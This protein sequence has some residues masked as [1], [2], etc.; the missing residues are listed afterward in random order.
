MRRSI[1]T[2]SL[3][4]T[5]EEKL[6]AIAAARFHAIELFENDLIN[7][8]GSPREVRRQAE[9]L[10]LSID[11][12]QP[13]RD[14]E[15]VTD[16]RFRRNLDRAERKFDIMA[17]L[18]APM[19]LV[20]SNV[21]SDASDDLERT[22]AQL[23]ALAERAARRSVRIGY[24]A[25]AWGTRVRTYGQAWEIV[26]RVD[27]PHLGL[28]V[29]SFHTLVLGDDPAGIAEI[30]REK[31]FFVQLADA[32]KL[33]MDPLSWSRHFRCFPGQG[34]LD[35]AGFTVPVIRSGYSGPLSLEVFNDVFR[36]SN[37]RETARDA[38]RSL[39]FLEEQVRARLDSGET[40]DGSPPTSGRRASARRVEL[41]DPP[42]VPTLAGITFLELAADADAATRLAG[43]L[44]R[45]GFARAGQHR[46]K[47]VTL[48]RQ[49]EI[50]LILNSEPESFAEGFFQ[51]HGPSL[52]ALGLWTGDEV[53]A[54]SRATALL[55]TQFE[56]RVGPNELT[57]PAIRSVDG[58]L[59]YFVGQGTESR[60]L[61]EIDFV[62]EEA[63]DAIPEGPGLRSIDH[64]AMA[65]PQDTVDTWILFYRAILGLEPHGQLEMA[66]PYGLMRSR[67]VVSENR[68]LRFTLNAS[69]GRQSMIARSLSTFAGPGVHHIAF[70]CDDIL[71]TVARL[72]AAGVGFLPVPE[73]YYDDLDARFGDQDGLIDRLRGAG[74]L[75]DRTADGEFFHVPTE[76]FMDRFSFEIVQRVGGYDGHGEVNAPAYLAAQSRALRVG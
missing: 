15:G 66:E 49:G 56:G 65:L 25:L 47:A 71:T 33:T 37:T 2:V 39:L 34:E 60:R 55:A 21:Q 52:C 64:I 73:N 69:E 28:I 19:M 20:C 16:D 12:F 27:H 68:A 32:P 23:R 3:S 74:V 1:A 10:G 51:L 53:Q 38:M 18:G 13:F 11:L 63:P 67:A 76:T 61:F 8:S 5:L 4:G 45:L 46:S 75:Y 36:A 59:M 35:V 30:P 9:D 58:S 54:M 7:F 24:E 29:D 41:F 48:Y 22:A 42:P 14:F 44:G 26:R 31:L 43:L 17:E 6:R 62:P 72:R 70:A 50:N 57:I 40:T